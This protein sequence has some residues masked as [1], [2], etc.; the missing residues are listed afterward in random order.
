MATQRKQDRINAHPREEDAKVQPEP[1]FDIE[2]ERAGR[3]DDG[4]QRPGVLG[5]GVGAG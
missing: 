1:V 5:C 2:E 4:V 3:F